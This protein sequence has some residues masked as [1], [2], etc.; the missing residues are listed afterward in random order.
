MR[1]TSKPSIVR[2]FRASPFLART[3]PQI[4]IE[5]HDKMPK[6]DLTVNGKPDAKLYTEQAEVLVG[7]LFRSLPG[8]TLDAVLAAML[9]RKA[10][11]LRVPFVTSK[12]VD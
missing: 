4:T 10:S 8:G 3:V 6:V 5:I 11:L 1:Q 12:E 7:A 9:R 2:L